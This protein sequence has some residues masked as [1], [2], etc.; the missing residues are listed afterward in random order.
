MDMYW[1][2]A[3]AAFHVHDVVQDRFSSVDG[4]MHDQSS[5]EARHIVREYDKEMAHF[6]HEAEFG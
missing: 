6:V 4:L 3:D 2:I 1:S 5:H